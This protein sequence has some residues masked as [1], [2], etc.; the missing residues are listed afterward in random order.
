MSQP[1]LYEQD[2]GV[3]T[4]TMNRPELRNALSGSDMIDAFVD[5][6]HRVN[7]DRSVRAVILTGAG[8]AFSSG[9]N[10]KTMREKY[11][12]AS[13][14]LANTRYTYRDGIQRLPMALAGIEVPLIAA[15]NGPAIGAG[16][17]LACM[18]DIRIASET[19]IFAESFVKLGIVPGDGGAWLL[20]RVIG[21]S[22]AC[23]MTFTGEPIDAATA[24]A[25]GLVSRVVPAEALLDHARKLAAKI[26]ANPGHALRMSKRLLKEGQHVRLDTLL[27]LSASFQALAHQS[28]DHREALDAIVEKRPPNFNQ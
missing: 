14:D 11:A 6:A 12:N 26:A 16:N 18:C 27:E 28:A 3:V 21:M 25:Y 8:T 22:R 1:L 5:A 9:G 2:G 19:A 20:P 23:E 13:G 4:L 15:V 24:L 17:D 7:A 10:V